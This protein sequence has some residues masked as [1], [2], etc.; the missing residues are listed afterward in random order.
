MSKCNLYIHYPILAGVYSEAQDVIIK[1]FNGKPARVDN[2]IRHSIDQLLFDAPEQ[3]GDIS[4]TG[5]SI[6]DLLDNLAETTGSI[7]SSIDVMNRFKESESEQAT[8][9]RRFLSGWGVGV[10][11]LLTP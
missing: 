5:F 2:L 10:S 1:F 4:S 3:F 11:P 6:C 7:P 9:R 8:Q